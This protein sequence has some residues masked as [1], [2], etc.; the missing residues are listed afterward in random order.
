MQILLLS[1]KKKLNPLAVFINY[2]CKN[3]ISNE[4]SD[5]YDK[6]KLK[7]VIEMSTIY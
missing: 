6:A 3:K 5:A 1:E 2:G 7:V 4:R